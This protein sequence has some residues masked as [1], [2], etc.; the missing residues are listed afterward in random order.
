[1]K[2][3][4]LSI[5]AFSL[6]MVSCSDDKSTGPNIKNYDLP[7][8]YNFENVN[9]SGQTTRLAMVQEIIDKMEGLREGN[10][11]SSKQ[12]I[13]MMNNEGNLFTDPNLNAS[14]KNIY[15]KLDSRSY[16]YFTNLLNDMDSTSPSDVAENGKGGIIHSADGLKTYFINAKGHDFGEMME[17]G[18]MGALMLSQVNQYLSDE[19]I[20][21]GV[22]NKTVVDGEGTVMQHHW[23]EAY[24]YFGATI[25]FP[26]STDDLQ[27]VSKYCN[28]LNN[29]TYYNKLIMNEGYLRGRVAINNNDADTKWESVKCVKKYWELVFVT[30]AIHYLNGAKASFT[31]DALRSHQLSECWGLLWAIQYNNVAKGNYYQLALDKIGDNFWEISVNQIDEAIDILTEGY[32][33][34][35]IKSEL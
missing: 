13:A 7:S 4:L 5:I 27:F 6:F 10:P 22:D 30:T 26:S 32:Q 14:D 31:D 34:Q 33:L 25:G 17:K 23:D 11:V 35:S 15:S 24:G 18:L 2:K 21:I 12:I 28:K 20:G 8:S 16:S 19:N 9:F 1:M 29:I 3:I